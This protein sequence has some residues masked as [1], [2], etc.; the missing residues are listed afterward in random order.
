M[1]VSMIGHRAI[2]ASAGSGKTFQ[3]AHRYIELISRGVKPDRIIA[4]TF[5]RKAAGEI[6]DS[7]VRYLCQAASSPEAALRTGKLIGKPDM[8]PQEFLNILRELLESL[9][10]LHIGTLDSFTVGIARA[11]PMEIGIPPRFQLLGEEGAAGVVRQ[12]VLARVFSQGE[13]DKGIRT[14]FLQAYRQA[15]FGQEEKGLGDRLD[16][17]I[18]EHHGHYQILPH[19]IGWGNEDY[20]W[21]SGTPW[22]KNAG[23]RETAARSLVDLLREGGLAEKVMERWQTFIAAVLKFGIGSS[24]TKDIDYLF[25][26][27]S[28]DIESLQAGDFSLK[29]DRVSQH[30][31]CEESRLALALMAHVVNT[32][33]SVAQQ[34]TQGIYRLLDLYENFYDAMLRRQGHLTFSDI[35]YLLTSGNRA[36]GG[37][38]ISRLPSTEARLYIDY[39]LDCKLDHWLLDEFQDTSDL[40]WEVLQNLAD[41]I[42]QD[43]S[44]QRSL[45]YVGDTKQAIYGWRGG[46]ARLFDKLLDHYEE[47]IELSH[48]STSFRSCRAVIDTV[49]RVFEDIPEDLLTEGAIGQW[50]RSWQTH[51]CEEGAVPAYGYTTIIEPSS[52]HG[53]LKPGDEDRYRVVAGLLRQ[54]NPLK[55]GLS[56]AILMRSNR[57]GEQIVD[58]LRRECPEMNIIHEGKA[59]IKDNPVVS[60]L[61]SLVKFAAHPG[62]TLAWRHLQMSPLQKYFIKE[63]LNRQNLSLVLLHE[64]QA[65]GFHGFITAWGERLDSAH[66]LDGF[67]RKR[68]EELINAAIEFDASGSRDCNAFLRFIDSYQI[69][70]LASSEAIR[71]MTIH[72]SKG[73]GFDV[74]L[75][76]DLQ[77]ENMSE[78]G[79][80]GFLLAR[81]EESE[82]PMWAL[83]MPRRIVA[84]TD[85]VLAEQIK[86]FDET[87]A[88]DSLCLLYVAM[89]RAKQGMYIVSSFPGKSSKSLTHAAFIKQQLLGETKPVEGKTTRID[90][91]EFICLYETGDPGWYR[92]VTD[93]DLKPAPAER[94]RLS[95]D[96]HR[97]TSIRQRLVHVQPSKSEISIRRAAS[98]FSP[99][100]QDD[101]DLGKALHELFEKISWIDE[102]NAGKLIGSWLV[103]SRFKED[104]NDR[105]VEHFRR[106]LEAKEIRNIM[107]RPQGNAELWRERRFEVILGE[108]WITGVFDRVVIEQEAANKVVKATI[109]DFKSDRIASDADIS[110]AVEGYR[111]QLSLY[112]SALSQILWLDPSKIELRLVFTQPGKVY[113]LK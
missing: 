60:V 72:Q 61:L 39:R 5:S 49:N 57:S 34:K 15:T 54:L 46:N 64:L 108:R 37:S 110:T 96:Y 76:P 48:L 56:T 104:I 58:Y 71:V 51:Q 12:Q 19:A 6:F 99:D 31:S 30:L 7:V 91:E 18:D 59:F 89:T 84:E 106:A 45:F 21:T 20:I 13:I 109:I 98:L 16:N 86:V 94:V 63:R 90:G 33:M 29:I 73:L 52:D 42:L 47:R 85:E 79:Q 77:S 8:T 40:Q 44:G 14:E 23:N 97:Q 74:V 87:A 17:L 81:D 4:L 101:L 113:E 10:R 53:N 67:G 100:V 3:L 107:S 95:P 65:G 68:L 55:R 111:S 22:W 75:L 70:D 11:F 43:V 83:E 112:R 36:S 27:L 103:S 102:V 105:A 82:E 38:V 62:D 24:W 32:E 88:F 35:Q 78:G 41:E 66:E 28:A 9:H 50:A 93:K 92:K 2:S 25:E 69:H 26:K 80:P 1:N